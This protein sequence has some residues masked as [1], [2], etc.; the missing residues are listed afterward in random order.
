MDWGNVLSIALGA[1]SFAAGALLWYKGSIEKQYAAQRD[2][3]HLKRQYEQMSS[4]IT[5]QNREMDRRLD[6]L[7]ADVRDVKS[8]LQILVTRGSDES[9]SEI[10]NR[11]R[12][13]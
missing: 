6:N 7:E 9:I 12:G 10:L 8:F 2:F 13:S 1:I 11:N 3:G 5:Q 4:I